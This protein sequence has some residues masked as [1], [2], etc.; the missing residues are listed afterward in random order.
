MCVFIEYMQ[1]RTGIVLGVTFCFPRC[2]RTA[3]L[4][5]ENHCHTSPFHL[6]DTP[7]SGIQKAASVLLTQS[8]SYCF[9]I[10]VGAL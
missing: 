10:L 7:L 1:I 9:V 6:I 2:D 5:Y 8:R 4:D 3:R